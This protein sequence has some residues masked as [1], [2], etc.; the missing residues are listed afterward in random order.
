MRRSEDVAGEFLG[1]RVARDV[2]AAAAIGHRVGGAAAGAQHVGAGAEK[3]KG[4]H[5]EQQDRPAAHLA[6]EQHRQQPDEQ[7]AHAAASATAETAAPATEI[8]D[9][10]TGL[11]SEEH[12]S[13]LQSLM[14]IPYA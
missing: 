6:A 2:G 3:D 7:P 5:A 8:A 9:I 12:T 11:R 10:V 13:E 4:E 14:R 1:R